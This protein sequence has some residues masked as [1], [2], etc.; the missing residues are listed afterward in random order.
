MKKITLFLAMIALLASC[1]Q[2]NKSQMEK[3]IISYQ[4]EASKL[5]A[6]I[7]ALQQ[8]ID[9]QEK[10]KDQL[11]GLKVRIKAETI[12]PGLFKHYFEASGSV[13]SVNEAFI[14]P[15][16]SGQVEEVTVHEGDKVIKG[17]LLARLSTDII[18]NNIKE[19]KASLALAEFTYKKQKSLW[20]KNIGSELDYVRAKSNM[21]SLS[22]KLKTLETQYDKSF[23]RSPVSG[24]VDA[25]DIKVG[26]LASPGMRL[27]HVVNIEDLYVNAQISENYLPVVHKGDPVTLTFPT[28]PDIT[29]KEKVYRTGEVIQA[30]NRTFKLQLKIKNRNNLF[31]PNMLALI[32]INDYTNNKAMVVPSF[33]IR[34]DIKGDYLFTVKKDS[35]GANIAHKQYV[36]TGL[37]S[38]R[39]TE[40]VKGIE[41]G[42]MV[43]T[44]GFN[45]VTEGT[46]V[47]F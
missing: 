25:I 30:Q 16:V 36:T 34:K 37:S 14:S 32:N 18:E 5:N 4:K 2:E 46:I 31:K 24:Y 45:N 6:K 44:D 8:Q 7:S 21:E 27:F 38:G 17:Q 26:E 20:E 15:E 3:Q 42:E 22:S 13:E 11:S 40:V 28:Y 35:K 9:E 43:I 19:V 41:P 12:E 1:K 29:M 23:I 33:T 47:I 10:A 39:F